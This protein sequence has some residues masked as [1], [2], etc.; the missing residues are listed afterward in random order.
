MPTR[1]SGPAERSSCSRTGAVLPST[2]SSVVVSVSLS[3]RGRN[4][5]AVTV[6]V[7]A[8]SPKLRV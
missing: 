8:S 7:R 5:D 6:P 2:K 4:N 3:R 1:R